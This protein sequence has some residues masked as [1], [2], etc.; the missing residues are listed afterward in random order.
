MNVMP[1]SLLDLLELDLHLLAQL[2]VE[3]AERLVE[4]QHAR[5]VDERPG[6]R[7]A[8]PLAAGQLGRLPLLVALEADHAER[9]GDAPRALVA[10]HLPDHQ[11]VADVVADRHVREQGVVLEHGVDVAVERRRAV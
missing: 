4:Q 1:T 6:E 10:R 11:A 8:L 9:V 3:R 7:D 2:Q 5:P